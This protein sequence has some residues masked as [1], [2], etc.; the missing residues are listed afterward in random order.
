MH[1]A[2]TIDSNP[3][4]LK[5]C[6]V[7]LF[8]LLYHNKT[9]PIILHIVCTPWTK[10]IFCSQREYISHFIWTTHVTLCRYE[11]T[12]ESIKV[13]WLPIYNGLTLTTYFR[14]LLPS[15]L[16]ESIDRCLYMDVD[17]IIRWP[18]SVLYQTTMEENDRVAGVMTNVLTT[19]MENLGVDR[20][21]NAGVII[22]NLKARRTHTISRQIIDFIVQYPQW[23]K[24]TQ[25]IMGDQCGINYICRDHI[26]IIN[27][28]WNVT[29]FWF[30]SSWGEIN[31]EG[32]WYDNNQILQ[33]RSHPLIL[34]FA[35]LHK[36][37]DWLCV[38]PRKYTYYRYLFYAW[39]AEISDF[40]KFGVH[41]LTYPRRS[42]WV[43]FRFT[44][45]IRSLL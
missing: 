22:I 12:R 40:C 27:P 26:V 14:L 19:F 4:Y 18:L 15:L 41:I 1:I 35:G 39:L 11:V 38:H 8:S 5:Q 21:I 42:D 7:M 44:K 9:D 31:E 32:V 30:W 25:A 13:L 28:Q 34:H 29:P 6:F 36:P 10:E 33:A 43:V 24:G 37:C 17:L 20:Y 45:K 3:S 2:L 23:L 16:E